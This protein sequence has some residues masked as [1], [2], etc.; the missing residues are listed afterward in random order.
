[1]KSTGDTTV[2]N[3]LEVME[4]GATFNLTYVSLDVS[5]NIGGKRVSLKRCKRTGSSHSTKKRGTLT[6]QEQGRNTHP[7]TVH[8]SLIEEF[9]SLNVL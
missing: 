7:V 4:L 3:M 1:M 8:L 5:R 6:I 9:N 2:S